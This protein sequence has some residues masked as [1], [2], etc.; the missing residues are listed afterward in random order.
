MFNKTVYM[1]TQNRP[2]IKTYFVPIHRR[3]RAPNKS[4]MELPIGNSKKPTISIA[5]Q[6][7]N[8]TISGQGRYA[9]LKKQQLNPFIEIDYDNSPDLLKNLYNVFRENFIAEATKSGPQS[10]NLFQIIEQRDWEKLKHYS[11]Y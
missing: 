3:F 11:R 10:K 2:Q 6:T 9:V 4:K 1:S 7:E 8:I 5:T